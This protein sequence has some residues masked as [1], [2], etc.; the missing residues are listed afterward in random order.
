MKNQYNTKLSLNA[1]NIYFIETMCKKNLF[2][3]IESINEK[4]TENKIQNIENELL[5]MLS[6]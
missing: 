6:N 3:L 4:I 1:L 2:I 5:C